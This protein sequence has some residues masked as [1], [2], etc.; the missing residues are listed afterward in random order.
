MVDVLGGCFGKRFPLSFG[1]NGNQDPKVRVCEI[2]YSLE[3]DSEN[4]DRNPSPDCRRFE[5]NNDKN[6]R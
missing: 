4:K 6:N 2:R 1:D 3:S 5:V